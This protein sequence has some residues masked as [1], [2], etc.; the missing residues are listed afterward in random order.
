VDCALT[1]AKGFTDDEIGSSAGGQGGMGLSIGLSSQLVAVGCTFKGGEEG[2]A[3]CIICACHD[4]PAGSAVVIVSSFLV[5]R[6]SSVIA[7]LADPLCP[8]VVPGFA[9]D[10]VGSVVVASGTGVVGS[11]NWNDSEYITPTDAQPW[12][13][14]DGPDTA[15]AHKSIRLH[16]PAGVHC[17]LAASLVPA[18]APL[19]QFDDQLW[20]GLADFFVLVPLVTQGLEP[21]ITLGFHVPA[22]LAGLEGV[23]IELQPF[24]P[25]LASA[26]EPGKSV[27]G[28]VAEIIVRF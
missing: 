18:Y 17:L 26:S 19:A 8:P 16:G 7:G 15:G 25:G 9:F 5:V 11:S 10:A 20:V 12:L 24:F 4:G 23:A 13:D 28:N 3:T 6:G 21:P 2:F 1:G 22:S 14:I 27:A